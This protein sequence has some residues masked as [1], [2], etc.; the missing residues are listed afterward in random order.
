MVDNGNWLKGIIHEADMTHAI[1]GKLSVVGLHSSCWLVYKR[2][3]LAVIARVYMPDKVDISLRNHLYG[4]LRGGYRFSHA[5]WLESKVG[6]DSR[7]C[8]LGNRSTSCGPGLD[9]V[10]W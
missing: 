6:C 2:C 10:N 4:W 5:V 1:Y 3:P 9:T 8:D 7:H